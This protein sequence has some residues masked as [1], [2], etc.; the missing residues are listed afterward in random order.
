MGSFWFGL[1][2]MTRTTGVLLS[3]FIAVP[4]LKKILFTKS[5]CKILKYLMA[6]WLC[7]CFVLLPPFIIQYVVPYQMHCDSKIDRTNAVPAWCLDTWPSCYAYI[8]YVYWDNQFMA[9]M[10]RNWD[11]F[12]V[13]IPMCVITVSVCAHFLRTQLTH[14]AYFF[15]SIA[16]I[17]LFANT[18][19]NSRVASTIPLYYWGSAAILTERKGKIATFIQMHNLGYMLVNCVIFPVEVGFI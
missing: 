1:A 17:M 9:F 4:M 2:A 14:S 15:C 12:I 8:Q 10:A 13:S 19:I 5:Y 16:L 7:A 6:S 18:D 3:V 11:N